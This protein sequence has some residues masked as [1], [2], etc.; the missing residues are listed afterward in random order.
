LFFVHAIFTGG[1]CSGDLT[2]KIVGVRVSREMLSLVNTINNMID[3]LA[4]F[5]DKVKKVA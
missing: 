3:Q 1:C 4:V 2:E 5:V